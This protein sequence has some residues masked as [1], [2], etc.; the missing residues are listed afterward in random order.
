MTTLS[1]ILMIIMIPI[2]VVMITMTLTVIATIMTTMEIAMIM[3]AIFRL[4]YVDKGQIPILIDVIIPLHR[5]AIE[6][7]AVKKLLRIRSFYLLYI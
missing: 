6:N 1:M 4:N 7:Q 5:K 2:T 3:I